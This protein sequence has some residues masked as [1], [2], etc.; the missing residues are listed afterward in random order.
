MSLYTEKNFNSLRAKGD[1]LA[2]EAVKLLLNRPD[3]CNDINGWE[4]LPDQVQLKNYPDAVQIYFLSFL[5]KPDFVNIDK[6]KIAQG[7]FDKE[8]NLYMALLGFYSLPYCYAFADGAQVLILS[9]RIIED[10][11]RRLSETA[12]FLLDSFRPGTF[13]NDNSSIMTIA[14]VRLIHAFS[15]YFVRHYA[16]DW[17]QEWGTPINQEDLLGTNMAFSLMVM[18]GMEKLD[19]FPG[20]EVHEAVLHYWKII[21]YYLGVDTAYWPE[22]AKEAFELEKLIRRRNLKHSLAGKTLTRSLLDFFENNLPNQNLTAFSETMVAYFLG[23]QAADA[24]GIA[25][26]AKLPKGLYSLLLDLSFIQQSG[27]KSNYLKTRNQFLA[28]SK[29]RFG[30]EL[31]LNIP[32]I[33]RS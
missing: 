28:Q 23:K 16:K 15:R 11:G 20:I 14:K 22:T 7:F 17:Q 27:L 18:R 4:N 29:I 24:V 19:K 13:L 31:T 21:G 30:E 12:L 2:D 33:T 25:Q 6:V 10:I 9:K 3:L 1:D 8:S 26:K 32:V 5:E